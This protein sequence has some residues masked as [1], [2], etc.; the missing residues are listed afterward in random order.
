M[1]TEA[2][3]SDPPVLGAAERKPHVLELVHDLRGLLAHDLDRVLVA[4]IVAS[5]DRVEHVPLQ[6]VLL[7]HVAERGPD[8]SLCRTGV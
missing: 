6:V 8:T 2:A 3:L 1:T 5:L 4:Q 7:A